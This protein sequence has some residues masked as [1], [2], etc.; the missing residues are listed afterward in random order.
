MLLDKGNVLER[1]SFSKSS[2]APQDKKKSEQKSK[3]SVYELC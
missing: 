1:K 2:I 3:L